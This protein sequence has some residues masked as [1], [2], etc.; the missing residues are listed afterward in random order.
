MRLAF[1]AGV[2]IGLEALVV[3]LDLLLTGNLASFGLPPN[4]FF[5]VLPSNLLGLGYSNNSQLL[6]IF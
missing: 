3:P 4:C 6:L 5:L 2:T 1:T